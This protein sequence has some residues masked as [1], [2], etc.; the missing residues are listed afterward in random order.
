MWASP[1]NNKYIP[2]RASQ[3]RQETQ[4]SSD[5]HSG[6]STSIKLNYSK[7]SERKVQNLGE[8]KNR[9]VKI[10]LEYKVYLL[11]INSRKRYGSR[12]GHYKFIKNS[13]EMIKRKWYQHGKESSNPIYVWYYSK[14]L[15]STLFLKEWKG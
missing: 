8:N 13:K 7:S 4:S 1:W 11:V 5:I 12:G 10:N 6:A 9:T 3:M 15:R 2:G 14:K